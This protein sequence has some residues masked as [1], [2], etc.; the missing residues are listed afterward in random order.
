VDL[1][2]RLQQLEQAADKS[3]VDAALSAAIGPHPIRDN[4]RGHLMQIL[5]GDVVLSPDGLGGKTVAGRDGK[6]IADAVR[7]KLATPEFGHFL[8]T[9][10]QGSSPAP[11]GTPPAGQAAYGRGEMKLADAILADFVTQEAAKPGGGDPRL[12]LTKPFGI[13]R[14]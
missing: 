14:S 10:G 12:D 2:Q 3:I 11:L 4:A 8:N 7:E 5:R 9:D 6:P 1:D 13:Q